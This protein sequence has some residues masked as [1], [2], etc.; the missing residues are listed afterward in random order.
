[1]AC[2]TPSA[3]MNPQS[4]QSG[5]SQGLGYFGIFNGQLL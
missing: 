1:M 4:K 3:G 5:L 2:M